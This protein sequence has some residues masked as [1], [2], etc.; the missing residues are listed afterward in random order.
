MSL[1]P[2]PENDAPIFNPS[3]YIASQTQL[4]ISTADARYLK[5]SGGVESGLVT[6]SSGLTSVGS[7]NVTNSTSSTSSTTG[8]L[9][10]SGGIA[11]AT[12]SYFGGN[13]VLDG[14]NKS[15]HN[16][17]GSAANPSFSFFS[18][19]TTGIYRVG[20][21]N[22]GW[23]CAGVRYVDLNST[24][25]SLVGN[26]SFENSGFSGSFT[27]PTLTANRTYTLRDSSG[28]IAFL[29]DVP[30]SSNY[31]DLTTDQ[32][33][34]GIKTFNSNPV[35]QSGGILFNS[36]SGFCTLQHTAA[37]N[38]T[39]TLPSATGFLLESVGNYSTVASQ[40]LTL[41][42]NQTISNASYL[43]G[44][45]I[46]C[47][48]STY[49]NSVTAASG[50]VT[51]VADVL[52][53]ARTYAATN[54]GVTYTNASTLQITGPPISGTNVTLTTTNAILVDSGNMTLTNGRYLSAGLGS[55][56]TPI[57]SIAGNG[58]IYSS[59]ANT[60]NITTGGTLRCSWSTSTMT[61]AA[62]YAITCS[63]TATITSGS[64]GFTSAGPVA[65]SLASTA[66]AC[67]IRPTNNA[68]TGIFGTAATNVS[69]AVGGTSIVSCG[70][71]GTSITGTLSTT[72]LT[73]LNSLKIGANGTTAAQVL[74]GS[75]TVT[76][77]ST[78]NFG[79]VTQG[80]TFAN[81]FAVAPLI[82]LTNN[83]GDVF[84][85]CTLAAGGIST[86]G[87]TIYATNTSGGTTSAVITVRYYAAA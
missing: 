64:G 37:T 17:N 51:T 84:S 23:T 74:Y 24:R 85:G 46:N 77:S 83:S 57:F 67:A 8:A 32:V 68:N 4:N 78:A 70:T 59:A 1:Y 58:G 80:V 12:D 28:T 45:T 40:G 49:T 86:S 7:V 63:G 61:L 14:S 66:A 19:Q 38:A 6:F 31:V 75:V 13:L 30:T 56:T 60:I 76:F 33:I 87:M 26:L 65:S 39:V 47:A 44:T 29:S 10:V 25:L 34:S 11:S 43:V 81:A 79:F 16:R 21:G 71:T 82:Y 2:P 35:M 52:I 48:S 42:N 36:G 50:T 41:S 20:A 3:T 62:N 55:A 54:T 5:L 69:I 15:I 27:S 72:G 9:I 22:I 53:G 18:D 73:T